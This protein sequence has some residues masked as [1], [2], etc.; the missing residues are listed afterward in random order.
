MKC[1]WVKVVMEDNFEAKVVELFLLEGGSVIFKRRWRGF[2]FARRRGR[3]FFWIMER[4][5]ALFAKWSLGNLL[6][7]KRVV[8][9]VGVLS[10]INFKFLCGL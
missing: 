4:R 2:I 8:R 10:R 3:L 1:G 6:S 7:V 5:V 9:W